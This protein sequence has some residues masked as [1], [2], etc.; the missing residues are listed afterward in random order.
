MESSA[1]AKVI[2]KM[3]GFLHEEI[4]ALVAANAC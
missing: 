2:L 3:F 1:D 4:M